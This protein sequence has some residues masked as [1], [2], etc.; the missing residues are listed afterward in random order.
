MSQD[1]KIDNYYEKEGK[2]TVKD[3][4]DYVIEYELDEEGDGEFETKV[5]EHRYDLKFDHLVHDGS[6][7]VRTIPISTDLRQ[8]KLSVLMDRYVEGIAK[9]GYEVVQ[10][11]PGK[12]IMLERRYAA[13]VVDKAPAT[14]AGLDA[15]VVTLDVANL[16]QVKVDP[17]ARA[18]RVRLVFAHTNFRYQKRSG[19][20]DK[21]PVEF[22]VVLMIGY[23]NQPDEFEAGLPEFQHFLERIEIDAVR[24]FSL[25]EAAATAGDG[26]GDAPG[27]GKDAAEQPAP[28]PQTSDSPPSEDSA[29]D[30][31]EPADEAPP[32][33]AE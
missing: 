25:S 23:G 31:T 15:L 17:N 6:L 32:G 29:E 33:A 14:L 9:A 8:K 20:P 3:S 16:D 24:G 18:E 12:T 4:D 21:P 30:S 22:P 10:F 13:A 11:A 19:A 2:L 28:E 27:E 26:E 5:K 7:F 1:W